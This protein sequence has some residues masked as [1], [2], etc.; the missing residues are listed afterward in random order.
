M[1]NKI[2]DTQR[3]NNKAFSLLRAKDASA[4]NAAVSCFTVWLLMEGHS[5]WHDLNYEN[6]KN[7]ISLRYCRGAVVTY[8]LLT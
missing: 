6:T 3:Q 8:H 4:L 2:Y 1:D 5:I 7:C